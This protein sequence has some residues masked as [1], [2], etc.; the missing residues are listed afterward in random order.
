M[1]LVIPNAAPP[2]PQC[3]AALERLELP[4]LRQLLRAL[5]LDGE[6]LGRDTDLSPLAERVQTQDAYAD[7]LIPWGAQQTRQVPGLPADA[8]WGLVTPCHWAVHADHVAMHD[9][10]TL[11]LDAAESE[12]LM[13]AMAPYFLEDGL[14]LHYVQADTWLVRGEVLRALPTASLERVRGQAVDAWLPRTP[15]ARVIRRLQN[16]MQMLLYTH[17][18]NDARAAR[19]VPAVNSFWLSGTRD[20]LDKTPPAP[21]ATVHDELQAFALNDDAHG[22]TQ[23]WQAL[24]SGPLAQ[25]AQ[26]LRQY[27]STDSTP[28]PALTLCSERTARTW[29]LQPQSLIRKIQTALRGPSPTTILKAL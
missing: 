1:H 8:A 29:R 25:F 3:Q 2:G 12:A 7:G 22:W 13:Q 27:R 26:T 11:R 23:A 17:P 16:E 5:T 10:R 19:G 24:D 4:Q 14:T 20:L 6:L 9:P 28:L 21:A 18:I 15:A